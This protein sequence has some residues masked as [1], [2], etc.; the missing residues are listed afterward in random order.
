MKNTNK[1]NKENKD[2]REH[3][4]ALDEIAPL[5]RDLSHLVAQIEAGAAGAGA[6]RKTGTSTPTPATT[7]EQHC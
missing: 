3:S 5:R 1:K 2:L 6:T 4:R 7:Q